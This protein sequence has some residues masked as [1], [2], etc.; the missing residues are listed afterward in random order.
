MRI[1]RAGAGV[2]HRAPRLRETVLRA[3][4]IVRTRG[5]CSQRAAA[6]GRRGDGDACRAN[7]GVER[8]GDCAA[9]CAACDTR[10][11]M[12]RRFVTSPRT[13]WLVLACLTA[14]AAARTRPH[15]GGTLRIETQGDPWQ[16]PDGI[17][18]RLVLDTLTT[19]S[20]TGGAQPALAVR[21]E[22][23][24]AAHRWEFWIRPGVHFQDGEA[25]TSDTVVA[26][27]TDVCARP[28]PGWAPAL[29]GQYGEWDRRWCSS[30]MQRCRICRS[31]WR[32]RNS[33]LRARMR[34]A[35]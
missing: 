24:N 2:G 11:G 12:L 32:R 29:G 8:D 27:L 7:G 33:P 35:Q 23:Q 19:V 30:A 28:A 6:G 13:A 3:Y 17:A 21:W 4:E 34:K 26:A 5:G 25:L 22:S 20:D 9:R 14:S 31:C 10:C 18:R 1:G 16:M 15:Y